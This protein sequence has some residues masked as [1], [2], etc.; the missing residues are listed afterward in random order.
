MDETMEGGGEVSDTPRTFAALV[1]H[2]PEN[3]NE[4]SEHYLNLATFARSIER[5][6]IAAE[7]RVKELEAEAAMWKANHDNQVK[8]KSLLINRPDLGDR[9]PKIQKMLDENARLIQDWA[10]TDTA[11][12]EICRKAGIDVDG[13]PAHVPDIPELVE[14]LAKENA[15]LRAAA[16]GLAEALGTCTFKDWFASELTGKVTVTIDSD[17]VRA[18]LAAYQSTKP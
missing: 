2:M 1:D 4:W 14:K 9:A 7:A 10:D 5:R 6:A 17:K 12:R 18:S 8:L 13:T 16:D 11:V 3:S 15:K